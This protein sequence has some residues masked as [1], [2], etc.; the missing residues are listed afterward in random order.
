VR[1]SR[2][3]RTSSFRLTLLYAGLFVVSVT[4]LF[5]VVFLSASHT[6]TRQID[7]IV[8]D[9]LAEVQ[10]S[11][12]QPGLAALQGVVT[13]YA[14]RSP[15]LYYLL[16]D[17]HGAVLAGNLPLQPPSIGLVYVPLHDSTAHLRA[18]RGRGVAVPGGYL[19][20]GT[21]DHEIR[22][23]REAM[24]R[25]FLLSLL[26][27]V[28]LALL[29]GIIMSLGALRR[30]EAMGRASRDIVEGDLSRRIP[31]RGTND[32]FDQL[33]ASVNVMLDRIQSL[34]AGLQQVS[35][36][37]A[38]DLRTPLTRM[39]QRLELARQREVTV[40]GLHTALD[41][42]IA[43][44]DAILTTFSALLRIAQVE[45]GSRRA[46]FT[47][48][49]LSAL[50]ESLVEIYAPVAEGKSQ[51]LSGQCAPGLAVSG[52]QALLLQMF[53]NLIENAIR[54]CPS[55]VTIT[56]TGATTNGC[57][58]VEIRDAGPGIAEAFR[59]K[60]MTR[61]YRLEASRGTEGDGLGLSMVAAVAQLH[62]ATVALSDNAPGLRVT[63]R[64]PS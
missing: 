54:H 36:D 26:A 14:E 18:I 27:I 5:G 43:D 38:H 20:V 9:E 15:R 57:S 60:V 12:S 6:M 31:V 7:Q 44:V 55:G 59:D 2:L 25:G 13:A 32:E 8:A 58:V 11:V 56:V 41:G 64:F 50:L 30:V 62:G 19:F 39:R 17:D 1:L 24:I 47:T 21:S 42:S 53:A 16:Q 37:I 35:S 4:I 3:V 40:S 63:L 34:M 23:M 49:D 29:G 33:A 61:F 52:D 22:E 46:D 10:A 45:S 51:V 48:V 28:V